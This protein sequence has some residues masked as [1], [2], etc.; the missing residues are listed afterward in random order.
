MSKHDLLVIIPTYNEAENI[1]RLLN[2]VMAFKEGFDVL[3]V[4]DNSPDG[5][6][7]LVKDHMDAFNGRIFIVEREGKLGLGTA[8]ITGFR[9]ALEKGYDYIF[10][11]DADFSHHPDDLSKLLTKARQG[12]DLVIGSRYIKN[13]QIENWPWGRRLISFGGALYARFWTGMHIKDPTAGFVCYRKEV[14]NR[15][16]LDKI[17]SIGYGFQ[18]EM[19]FAAHTLGFRLAEVPIVFTDR[20]LGT[21]KMDSSIIKEA[22]LGTIKM[23]WAKWRGFS[24]SDSG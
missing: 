8:Y 4:D 9:W 15:I 12:N 19:K 5:T 6:G 22:A 10:E 1:I 3:V 17:T 18:I 7:E 13:G 23:R 16:D 11:M 14:L 2:E 20:K 21:S 24:Y